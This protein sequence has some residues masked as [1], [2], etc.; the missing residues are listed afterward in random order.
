MKSSKT[1][2]FVSQYKIVTLTTMYILQLHQSTDAYNTEQVITLENSYTK[3]PFLILYD[4]I[5]MHI[6]ENNNGKDKKKLTNFSTKL[7]RKV[8]SQ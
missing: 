8:E 2:S 1:F 3:Y 6:Y 4:V 5:R 7:T